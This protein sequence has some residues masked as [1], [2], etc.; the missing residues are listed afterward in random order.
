MLA[1]EEFERQSRSVKL[2]IEV[3][4]ANLKTI[5]MLASFPFWAKRPGVNQQMLPKPGG[6]NAL[7]VISISV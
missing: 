6:S 5:T 3:R 7:E 4:C 2:T 1:L